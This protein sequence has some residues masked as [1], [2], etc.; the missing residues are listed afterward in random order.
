MPNGLILRKILVFTIHVCAFSSFLLPG[1]S[2][3]LRYTQCSVTRHNTL[4]VYKV[5][6]FFSCKMLGRG[7]GNI[8]K[9]CRR[10]MRALMNKR[11]P[12]KRK[13]SSSNEEK[14]IMC[15]RCLTNHRKDGEFCTK[16]MLPQ[17]K[18]ASAS[19][20]ARCPGVRKALGLLNSFTIV[21]HTLSFSGS[22]ATPYISFRDSGY[23]GSAYKT[24][25]A[26]LCSYHDKLGK[27]C[28]VKVIPVFVLRKI[29]CMLWPGFPKTHQDR[30][31]FIPHLRFHCATTYAE[32]LITAQT[33]ACDGLGKVAARLMDGMNMCRKEL[34]ISIVEHCDNIGLCLLAY[35]KASVRCSV[36]EA[37][38]FSR[39]LLLAAAVVTGQ[40][41]EPVLW[42]INTYCIYCLHKTGAMDTAYMDFATK[43]TVKL[44]SSHG[45]QPDGGK[46]ICDWIN[47]TWK[48]ERDTEQKLKAL[49]IE[50]GSKKELRDALSIKCD[51]LGKYYDFFNARRLALD[52]ASVAN[53]RKETCID[54]LYAVKKEL[55]DK[56]TLMQKLSD[57]LLTSDRAVDAI[58]T[59]FE[60]QTGISRQLYEK[61][62][63]RINDASNIHAA[64]TVCV[65]AKK[66]NSRVVVAAD[67]APATKKVKRV[68]KESDASNM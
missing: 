44:L 62:K 26:L 27:T 7:G 4:H 8:E 39:T 14:V 55:A 65:Y 50:V 43:Y 1:I 59:S 66:F 46:W 53:Y 47:W 31:L 23:K 45:A 52:C 21:D 6:K 29:V 67:G 48:H 3:Y 25:I 24:C 60:V 30:M 33:P 11:Q 54:W 9:E 40:A 17:K 15:L 5:K 38:E 19:Y 57:F 12:Q 68:A 49:A 22:V 61:I 20:H 2:D 28:H 51:E 64:R 41:I 63:A 16:C 58:W 10:W 32:E 42:L 13:K 35:I 37:V 18:A 34:V 56:H 36:N